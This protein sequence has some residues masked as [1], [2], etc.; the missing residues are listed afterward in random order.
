MAKILGLRRPLRAT[1]I[2]VIFRPSRDIY[3]E[4]A[5]IQ[6]ISQNQLKMK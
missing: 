3:R 2:K 5:V 6:N 1:A 4:R